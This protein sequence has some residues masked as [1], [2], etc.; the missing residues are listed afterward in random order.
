MRKFSSLL[1]SLLAGIFLLGGLS[2]LEAEQ[3][4]KEAFANHFLMGVALS[5]A[6]IEG[7]IPGELEL[8]TQQFNCI[9]PENVMKWEAVHPRLN[10]YDFAA[11]DR[12]V[13]FGVRNGMF[14]VGHTLVWHSQVP[15]WVFT[16]AQGQ[17]LSRAALLERM[18]DHIQSVVG[19]YRG[20][21]KGWDVVNEVLAEDGT[22]RDSPWRQ[23]IGDDYIL[24]AFEFAHEADPQAELYYNDY[25]IEGGAK[26][27]GAIA[28]VKKIQA[29]G[30]PITGIG[31]QGH[32]N[33]TW[34][35]IE[36]LDESLS[37]YQKLGV[38]VMISELDVDVLPSRS[39]STSADVSRSEA[40]DPALNPYT[41]GLPTSVQAALA[42]RYAELFSLLLKHGKLISRVTLW[43]V[44][45]SHSW[46][47]NWPI[48]GRTSYPL[49]FDRNLHPKQAF[50]AVLEAA[51]GFNTTFHH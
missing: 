46:L 5:D 21:V 17:R 43:G 1:L 48:R 38:K 11:A 7:H 41:D 30:I 25:G 4:L 19:R 27:D 33:L 24:K 14:I 15:A 51:Q 6:Q 34:P 45:D 26:R 12:F 29:A 16:D 47:N 31:I 13:D 39:H 18:R 23:I 28:L 20:K 35:K 32:V 8:V 36:V 37:L 40:A 9:T 10:E 49:L 2:S 44:S 50:S 3:S 42:N 22:L